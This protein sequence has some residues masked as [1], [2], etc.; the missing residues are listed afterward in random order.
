MSIRKIVF[1]E[2]T[3]ERLHVFSRY[4]LPRLGNILLAT[5][6]KERGYEA[7]A[8]FL[9][10]K[11]IL[12]RNLEADLVAI[13]TITPTA[14]VAY[15]L[16]DHFRGRE[17][18]VVIGGPHVS[19]LPEEALQHADYCIRGEGESS[20]PLLVEALNGKGSLEEI[21]GLA[22]TQG[23]RAR[24]NPLGSLV[25]ELDSL[26]FCDFSLL[27]TGGRKLGPPY[28]RAMVP[29]QTS[30][31]CP[32]NC[33]FCSVT[34]MFGRRYRYRS[35]ENV[36]AELK[37]YD[38]RRHYL[39]FY[40][41]NFASNRSRAKELLE[42]MIELGMSFSWV[43]QVRSD[44][45]KDGELLDL[46]KRAGCQVLFIGFESVDPQALK[47]MRKG[48]SRE[49]IEQ[50]I[51]E[52]HK[53]R[54]SIHGMFV[55]GFDADTVDKMRSTVDFAI[56]KG[57]DTSQFLILTP[58][59]GTELFAS[60]EREDRIL[61]YQWDTYDGHHVKFRPTS[62]SLWELQKAQILAH[63]RFFAPRRV[64][65]RFLQGR[66]KATLAGVYAR[67]AIRR[68]L[69]REKEY[70]RQLAQSAAAAAKRRLPAPAP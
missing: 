29:V 65:E 4:V 66:F 2:P 14:T 51:L 37:R 69:R 47:E 38:P 59:P 48:Q 39:F 70:L 40:D 62:F 26:P 43:T 42:R 28:G 19:F 68:W 18:P 23:G 10:K 56:Q 44:V 58:L 20:F 33:T 17:M 49:E 16:A 41:D 36:I 5:I 57:I 63:A 45:A 9:S 3:G 30:R 67:G 6:M 35:T 7:S 31:G 52:I 21:P 13:S 12:E 22:W 8:L 55:F 15:E 64:L 54:I 1:L 32:F 27:D 53:R 46:M 60:L 50:A 61:D 11:E 24:I 34:C 25:Q